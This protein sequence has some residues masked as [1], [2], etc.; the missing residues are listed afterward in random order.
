MGKR[1]K[2]AKLIHKW[3]CKITN[4]QYNKKMINKIVLFYLVVAL[5]LGSGTSLAL[6]QRVDVI[7]E[8]MPEV[9]EP[10]SL[11]ER[12]DDPGRPVENI[13]GRF[14]IDEEDRRAPEGERVPGVERPVPDVT[15]DMEVRERAP[16]I[17]EDR[18]RLLE[19]RQKHQELRRQE[20]E[21]QRQLMEERRREMEGQR[22]VFDRV[23][24][25]SAPMLRP[26]EAR[27]NVREHLE[28]ER[29]TAR[30]QLQE[31]R[32]M[33][34][35]NREE[36]MARQR[37]VLEEGRSQGE[38]HR[39]EAMERVEEI[40]AQR[41]EKLAVHREELRQAL[42]ERLDE[43]RRQ[44]AEQMADRINFLN[45]KLTD[46]YFNRLD[47]F[48]ITLD[49]MD[50]RA[51]RLE[52][53]GI[54]VSEAMA[55]IVAARE[56]ISSARELV[57]IQKSKIYKVE[58]E[59]G[60]AP[61]E[62]FRR[63]LEELKEDHRELRENVMRPILEALRNVLDILKEAVAEHREQEAQIEETIEE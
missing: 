4:F 37:Q 38:A 63:V 14:N 5:L 54:D 32:E 43:R 18:Q 44:I 53:E 1:K 19:E 12:L 42:E 27:E 57:L 46:T 58:I 6:A 16:L 25:I 39:Q 9:R 36:A 13:P 23:G 28:E 7:P 11:P 34:V 60:E 17:P 45:D 3:G 31:A 59:E 30:V 26:V 55:E 24:P 41:E 10:E 15:S 47:A 61:G 51:E 48:M 29:Q 50:M 8:I 22:P 40:R 21:K 20:L 35:D 52:M 2:A 49:K 33:A 56:V 62:A